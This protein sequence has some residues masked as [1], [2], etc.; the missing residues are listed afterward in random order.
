MSELWSHKPVT[1]S[2]TSLTGQL[3][4][5][6]AQSGPTQ[7]YLEAIY[8][9]DGDGQRVLFWGHQS[10]DPGDEPAK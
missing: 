10:V 8:V 4:K 1:L 3:P 2:P 9:Q 5:S 6:K 7:P